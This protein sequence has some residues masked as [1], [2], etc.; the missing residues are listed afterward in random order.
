M[1]AFIYVFNY[2]FLLL[3]NLDLYNK[4]VNKNKNTFNVLYIIAL[5]TTSGP[6]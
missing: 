5:L 1:Y 2:S 3:C 4:K 6:H